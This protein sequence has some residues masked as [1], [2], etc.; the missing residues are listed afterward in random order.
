MAFFKKENCRQGGSGYGP[1]N[2]FQDL[3]QDFLG[4]IYD[5]FPRL[6]PF[7]HM[8]V[9]VPEAILYGLRV[10][11]GYSEEQAEEQLKIIKLW[12]TI[13]PYADQSALYMIKM[14]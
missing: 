1:L 7:V 3:V 9:L 10:T 13:Q 14:F 4:F 2:P 12:A 5:K 11:N 6:H 8:D